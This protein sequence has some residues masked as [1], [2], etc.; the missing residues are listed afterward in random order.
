MKD[1]KT[2]PHFA[3]TDTGTVNVDWLNPE[4]NAD[5]TTNLV[6]ENST[7]TL[8]YF[9]DRIK[10]QASSIM[11]LLE[12]QLHTADVS[13]DEDGC[14]RCAG[15]RAAL[16]DRRHFDFESSWHALSV[17]RPHHLPAERSEGLLVGD[18]LQRQ[19]ALIDREGH[20]GRGGTT[21][22]GS[23]IIPI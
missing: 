20:Q 12:D 10:H 6:Y 19:S 22:S 14:H 1:P 18:E 7:D 11:R 16:H 5:D 23:A 3:P 8:M 2:A 15:L 9:A 17:G 21:P 13:L 4:K